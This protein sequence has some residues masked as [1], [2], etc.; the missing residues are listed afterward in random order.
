ML[1][2]TRYFA[3]ITAQCGIIPC[4][5][6]TC[7]V[8]RPP[9]AIYR[10]ISLLRYRL[11]FLRYLTLSN[12]MTLKSGLEVTQCHS[13]WYNSKAWVRFF[14][15]PLQAN[16]DSILHHFR[17][18]ARYWSK[19]VIFHTPCIRRPGQ[20]RP[21][22]NIAIPFGVK[23]TRMVGLPDGEKTLRICINVQTEYRRVTDRRTDRHLDTAQSAL[24]IRVGR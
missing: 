24:C 18:K 20:E 14:R 7:S 5:M 19:I 11:S 8:I 2:E 16:Y 3:T 21:R 15:L 6:N 12:I 10:F 23:K 13:N 1:Q 9:W 4:A 17:G 22:R